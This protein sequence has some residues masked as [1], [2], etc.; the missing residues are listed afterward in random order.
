M[1][2]IGYYLFISLMKSAWGTI[3]YEMAEKRNRNPKIA[4]ALGFIFGLFGVIGYA[5]AGNKNN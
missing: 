1:E 5:I 2:L 3:C 4:F